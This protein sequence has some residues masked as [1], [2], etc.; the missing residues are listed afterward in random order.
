MRKYYELLGVEKFFKPHELNDATTDKLREYA[1]KD[2]AKAL[3]ICEAFSV[4]SNPEEKKKYDS[5][6][7]EEYEFNPLKNMKLKNPDRILAEAKSQIISL[8]YSHNNEKKR[9]LGLIVGGFLAFIVLG[10]VSLA[11]IILPFHFWVLLF[12]ATAIS[13]LG[14]GIKGIKGY[15]DEKKLDK[16]YNTDDV[17][18]KVDLMS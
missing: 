13:G 7:D 16:R 8:R 15:F 5:L 4:L 11:T 18:D 14:A 2:E 12:P 17:W 9:Q 1:D 3:E 6:T 10:G